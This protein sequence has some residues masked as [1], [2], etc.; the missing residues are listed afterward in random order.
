[1][2][3]NVPETVEELDLE[4]R[5]RRDITNQIEPEPDDGTVA[6]WRRELEKREWTCRKPPCGVYNCA[7]HVWASRRTGIHEWQEVQKILDDDGYSH[8]QL[9]ECKIGDLALYHRGGIRKWLHIAVIVDIREGV[10]DSVVPVFLS[11]WDSS[12]GEYFHQKAEVPF[13][14]EVRQDYQVD[15]FT[16]RDV[17]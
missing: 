11:K 13:H 7:G 2:F 16:D 1:M 9:S 14:E 6:Y 12:S 10:G 8:I 5:Q 4:T 3:D 17:E 15:Y